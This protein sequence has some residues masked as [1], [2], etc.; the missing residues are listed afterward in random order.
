[1]SQAWVSDA[2]TLPT[3]AQPLRVAEFD[4][5]FRTSLR[6]R[7]RVSPTQLR[8]TLDPAAEATARDL[9][10]RETQCC[11][12]FTFTFGRDGDDL[13]LDVTVPAQHLEVLDSIERTT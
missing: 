7:D 9:C 1:M 4:E 13:V 5:L 10:A 11:S 6:S 12:F 3:A 2:C 8:L